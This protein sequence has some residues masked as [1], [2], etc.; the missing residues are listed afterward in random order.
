MSKFRQI[1]GG[2]IVA[3]VV[4]AGVLVSSNTRGQEKPDQK[5][6]PKA[7]MEAWEKS[8]KP[9]REQEALAKRVGSWKVEMIDYSMGEH[10]T[11]ATAE[12]KMLMGGRYQEIR[13]KGSMMGQP[14]EGC[15]TT[16]FD[17]VRKVY[18]NTWIDNMGTSITTA[19]GKATDDNTVEMKGKMVDPMGGN[20]LDFRN[21][22]K[23]IDADHFTYEIYFSAH[24]QEKK[25]MVS[26]YSRVN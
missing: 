20:M 2:L 10:K 14:F 1:V 8:M 13:I 25:F 12:I 26:N 7:M 3:C 5:P 21:V 19:E 15:S 17:N 11:E 18:E 23:N 4:T 6:D 16:A 22:T 9:G 24:G